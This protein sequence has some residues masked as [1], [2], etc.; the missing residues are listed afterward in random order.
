VNLQRNPERWTGYNGSHVWSA[1]YEEN[2]MR[3]AT[4]VDDMCY[5]ERVLFRLLSGRASQVDPGLTA[6]LVSALQSDIGSR[7]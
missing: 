1:I 3:A 5:E 4:S 6:R 7:V 2:C